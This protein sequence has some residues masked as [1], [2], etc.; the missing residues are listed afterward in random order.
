MV[1]FLFS[2]CAAVALAGTA[3]GATIVIAPFKDNTLFEGTDPLSNGAG[4]EIF[5]GRTGDNAMNRLRRALLQFDVA[6]AVPAGATIDNVTLT[7]HLVRISVT[8]NSTMRLYEVLAD[9]GEGTSISNGGAG[10]EASIGDATWTYAV[11]NTQEWRTAANVP[12]PGGYFSNTVSA[13]GVVGTTMGP[14][15]WSGPELISDV[16]GWL[17]MPG[18]NHG[19]ILLGN[20]AGSRSARGFASREYSDP[21][22]RPALTIEYTIPEPGSAAL[23]VA[24]GFSLLIRRTAFRKGKTSSDRP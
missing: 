16:Q 3:T 4:P 20:E 18:S 12:R 14:Y 22:Y 7:L 23:F 6:A 19:W 24:A 2:I 8:L 10:A 13:S 9:W 1:R 11:Y 21:A 5:A 15:S 17:D